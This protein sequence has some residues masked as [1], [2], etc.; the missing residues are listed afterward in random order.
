MLATLCCLFPILL[1]A[2]SGQ[3][4]VGDRLIDHDFSCEWR[5]PSSEWSFLEPRALLAFN[6]VAFAGMRRA[7]SGLTALLI[8]EPEFGGGLREYAEL[9]ASQLEEW[10]MEGGFTKGQ[11]SGQEA[12]RFSQLSV[13]GG[14]TVRRH[15]TVFGHQGYWFQL[16]LIGE[17][18]AVADAEALSRQLANGL[19]LL[20]RPIRDRRPVVTHQDRHGP[21][22][23][24]RGGLYL[25]PSL[26]MAIPLQPDVELL[27]GS[28]L[29][30]LG[31]NAEFGFSTDGDTASLVLQADRIPAGKEHEFAQERLSFLIEDAFSDAEQ[32][33][34]V[35]AHF[36]THEISFHRL[37]VSADLEMEV[38]VACLT[39]RG[40]VFT[41]W[42][43]AAATAAEAAWPRLLRQLE[44]VEFLREDQASELRAS[45]NRLPEPEHFVAGQAGFRDGVY[46]DYGHQFQWR[47]PDRSW[48]LWL[49]QAEADDTREPLFG[50]HSGE[51]GLDGL[52][53][54]D[55]R[56]RESTG[57][58]AHE[59]LLASELEEEGMKALAA[60][61]SVRIRGGE[62]WYSVLEET[63]DPAVPRYC[64]FASLPSR[65]API[66][67]MLFGY[68]PDALLDRG[69]GLAA[70]HGF[71][72]QA[73]EM[74][75]FWESQHQYEDQLFGWRFQGGSPRW[76]FE[77]SD[78]EVLGMDLSGVECRKGE[79]QA[80]IFGMSMPAE[81]FSLRSAEASEKEFAASMWSRFGIGEPQLLLESS[82]GGLPC[83]VLSASM[84]EREAQVSVVRRDRTLFILFTEGPEGDRELASL[85][86]SFVFLE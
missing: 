39:A 3:E 82:M 68:D 35:E 17:A 49:D 18:D 21:G 61:T 72:F 67:L 16:G 74:E 14:A 81:L 9:L 41:L 86:D 38:L 31:E 26:R 15:L 76:I 65:G 10:S 23:A 71:E 43:V 11:V 28:E 56:P 27:T 73:A 63:G 25:N 64:L 84:E 7:E 24:V 50:L 55:L 46:R 69:K 12:I 32:A 57:R 53:Y 37:L 20:P 51:H 60:P 59:E 75:R 33:G 83:Q 54:A 29:E 22:W 85:R 34:T 30:Q 8:A 79:R 6:D 19:R 66:V 42:G 5:L 70:V 77:R 48:R 40:R 80:V 52:V 2:P 78:K 58:K 4:I 1:Q 45:M 44:R 13:G 62:A 36:G 47:R